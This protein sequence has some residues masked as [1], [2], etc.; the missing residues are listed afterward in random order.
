MTNCLSRLV[1]YNNSVPSPYFISLIEIHSPVT[2]SFPLTHRILTKIN[3][4][5]NLFKFITPP[6]D[7]ISESGQVEERQVKQSKPLKLTARMPKILTY[8]I[9]AKNTKQN[10]GGFNYGIKNSKQ[11]RGNERS[12]ELINQ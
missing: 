10:Q 11:H 1:I 5:K 9:W 3:L 2:A 12:Q 6:S 7:V 4:R 8:A